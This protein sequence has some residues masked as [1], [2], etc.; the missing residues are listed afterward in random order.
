MSITFHI[1]PNPSSITKS[2][3][4]INPFTQGVLNLIKMLQ[5]YN[6]EVIHYGNE[7][8]EVSCEHR[9]TVSAQS[10]VKV[11]NGNLKNLKDNSLLINEF[12]TN[13]KPYLEKISK[14]DIILAYYGADVKNAIPQNTPNIVVE[15]AIGYVPQATFAPFKVY[16]SNAWRNYCYGYTNNLF[17]TSNDDTIPNYVNPDLFEFSTDKEDYYLFLGRANSSKG[18]EIVLDLALKSDKYFIIA[19]PIDLSGIN[20]KIHRDILEKNITRPNIEIVGP[21]GT[22]K[23][24]ALLKNAKA[25]LMPTQYVEPFGNVILESFYSGTPVIGSNFGALS[26]LIENGVT[27]FRCTEFSEYMAALDKVEFLDRKIIYNSTHTKYSF[28]K[29]ATKYNNYFNR[30][31]TNK[32]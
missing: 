30:I 29:I 21:V 28:N 14:D 9:S 32:Q 25:F 15:P 20:S 22:D 18:I 11:N 5:S 27:G 31:I 26:E 13:T 8:S 24:R 19:G 23:R 1:L 6:Y 7:L 17:P 10:I 3:I 4:L 12:A 16:C 2:D